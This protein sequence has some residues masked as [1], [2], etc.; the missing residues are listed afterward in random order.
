MKRSNDLKTIVF[1][2]IICT[3]PYFKLKHVFAI[4]VYLCFFLFLFNFLYYS[5]RKNF[6]PFFLEKCLNTDGAF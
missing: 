4:Y 2:H 5:G 6:V 1:L 3:L